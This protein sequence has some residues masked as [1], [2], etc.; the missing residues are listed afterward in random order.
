MK[1]QDTSTPLITPVLIGR[2]KKIHAGFVDRVEKKGTTKHII[3]KAACSSG[4]CSHMHNFKRQ[5]SRPAASG[6][7][8]NC[9]VCLAIIH[10]KHANT[11]TKAASEP[12]K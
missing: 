7:T 4:M 9:Q 2:G 1:N 3:Y 12:P 10:R 5:R 8:I 11:F 6:Q